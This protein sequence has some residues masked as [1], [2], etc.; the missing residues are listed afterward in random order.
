[1]ANRPPS[2][3]DNQPAPNVGPDH[4]SPTV[5][6]QSDSPDLDQTI[7][8]SKSVSPGQQVT[9]NASSF[10]DYEIL[11]EIAREGMESL[12]GRPAELRWSE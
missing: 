3:S 5:L 8:P 11:E 2:S 4:D 7:A 12:D 9:V 6:P 1:M 10:A